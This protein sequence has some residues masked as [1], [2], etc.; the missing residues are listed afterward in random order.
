VY[1]IHFSKQA[2]RAMRKVP[3]SISNRIR[4][5]LVL[6]AEDPYASHANVTKLQGRSGYRLRIGK[7]RVIYEIENDRLIILVLR[8]AT[9]GEVYR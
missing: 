3:S 1:S 5:R 8:V 6:I 2:D 4:E 7:W 9:R